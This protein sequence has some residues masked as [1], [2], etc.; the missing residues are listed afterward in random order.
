MK[1]FYTVN[2]YKDSELVNSQTMHFSVLST[3]LFHWYYPQTP[4]TVDIVLAEDP[5]LKF[6]EIHNSV[7]LPFREV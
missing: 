6:E 1:D 5:D 7:V 3:F 2:I 4:Y